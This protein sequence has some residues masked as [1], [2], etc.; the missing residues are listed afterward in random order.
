MSTAEKILAPHLKEKSFPLVDRSKKFFTHSE[1]PGKLVREGESLPVRSVKNEVH[2]MNTLLSEFEDRYGIATVKPQYIIGPG[3]KDGEARAVI[4]CDEIPYT[5]TAEVVL[6]S[7]KYSESLDELNIKFIQHAKDLSD[8]GG[9][10]NTEL[11]YLGQYVMAED[12][13]VLVDV[14]PHF[15]RI[16][17]PPEARIYG[18]VEQVPIIEMAEAIVQNAIMLSMNIGHRSQSSLEAEKFLKGIEL[19]E[20]PIQRA[21]EALLRA[22]QE[23]SIDLLSDFVDTEDD[24][25]WQKLQYSKSSRTYVADL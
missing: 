14:E 4:V 2:A 16:I 18:D 6:A 5:E 9:I 25:E 11:M 17:A 21:R 13:P 19:H 24:T 7:G 22:L 15:T 20:P 1:V 23:S 10:Y 3:D 8:E 12:T